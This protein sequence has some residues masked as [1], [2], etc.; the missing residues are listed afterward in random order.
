[1]FIHWTIRWK[2]STYTVNTSSQC[3]PM[4]M[5]FL[6]DVS[7]L[8]YWESSVRTNYFYL[9][10]KNSLVDLA[11]ISLFE[12][13]LLGVHWHSWICRLMIFPQRW[14]V[15][16]HYFLKYSLCL[17]L[18]S[19]VGL[20]LVYVDGVPQSPRLCSLF[21]PFFSLFPSLDYLSWT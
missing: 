19:P 4:S 7:C 17:S 5:F 15:F 11:L 8:S 3:L 14:K 21:I 20:H 13:I 6:C 10:T 18:S 16:S 2:I 1:M 12:F 9:G